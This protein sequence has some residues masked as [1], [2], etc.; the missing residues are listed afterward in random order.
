MDTHTALHLGHLA[1]IGPLLTYVGLA[2]DNTPV[3][4][5]NSLGVAAV[6]IFA[7]H[8]YRAYGKLKENKSAW[9]NWIH[10]LFVAPLL[11]LVAYLKKDASR[12]YYEMILLLGVAAIGYHGIYLVRDYIQM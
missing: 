2:R 6:A 9:V 4:V 11:F 1:V 8:C 5:L 10:I 12:R 3:A 7:Y